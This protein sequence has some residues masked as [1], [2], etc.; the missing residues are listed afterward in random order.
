MNRITHWI[1]AAILVAGAPAALAAGA[2][3]VS[4]DSPVSEATV[5]EIRQVFLGKADSLGGSSVKPLDQTSG[6]AT[7]AAFYD[8]VAGMAPNQVK[9]YW[10]KQVFTGKG[11]PPEEV[12]DDAAIVSAVTGDPESIGYVSAGAVTGDVRVLLEF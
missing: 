1:I 11:K 2:V 3:I 4:A 7:R 5:D 10:A 8:A 12:G 9:S 6:S